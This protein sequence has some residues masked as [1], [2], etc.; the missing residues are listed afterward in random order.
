MGWMTDDSS[1]VQ[2]IAAEVK[3]I[4][5]RYLI[6]LRHENIYLF[7]YFWL[8]QHNNLFQCTYL[9]AKRVL[10]IWILNWYEF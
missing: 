10:Q 5:P 1:Q 9:Q 2:M 3:K 7:A 8:F 6:E 4:L